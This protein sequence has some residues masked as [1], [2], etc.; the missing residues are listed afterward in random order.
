MYAG[1]WTEKSRRNFSDAE[2][3]MVVSA[4]VV[5]SQYGNSV[6]FFMK[7]GQQGFIPLSNDSSLKLGDTVDLE[8]AQLI[9]LGRP[10]DAD[11]QRVSI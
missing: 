4:T 6:C 9:V 5:S 7:N 3:S 8:K 2:R 11:I 1:K 10:G